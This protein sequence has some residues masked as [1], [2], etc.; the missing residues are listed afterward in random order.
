MAKRLQNF[1]TIKDLEEKYSHI[2][3]PV[4]MRAIRM[5]FLNAKYKDNVDFSFEKLE[6]NIQGIKR[7]D[8][9]LKKLHFL[10][11]S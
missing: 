11:N 7:I 2:S 10:L 6:Q 8:E 3:H 5:C 1:Y 4:L 9:S